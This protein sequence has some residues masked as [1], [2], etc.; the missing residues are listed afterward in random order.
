MPQWFDPLKETPEGRLLKQVR[1]LMESLGIEK[2]DN[3][4]LAAMTEPRD[5]VT[6]GDVIAAAQ[7]N[8]RKGKGTSGDKMHCD[9]MHCKEDDCPSCSS[10]LKKA[11]VSDNCPSC[12]ANPH[13]EC[14]VRGTDAQ[15]INCKM[16]PVAYDS[17]MDDLREENILEHIDEGHGMGRDPD[18]PMPIILRSEVE[19]AMQNG[20]PQYL[21][22]A[23]GEPAR[24]TSY[25][26][27]Q[28]YIAVEDGKRAAPISEVFKMPS[29]SQTGYGPTGSTLHMHINDG[30]NSG[31]L[32]NR[33][34]IEE[35]LADLKKGL[36]YGQE[37]VV[38][39]IVDLLE[40]VYSRL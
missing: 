4:E 40:Q 2:R 15:A 29:V 7:R 34:P 9:K 35:S 19:S 37:G 13:E 28:R 5:K 17:R 6:R 26:T 10:K 11:D 30:G 21:D 32:P 14:R 3:S 24:A 31:N 1:D 18:Q 8:Q 23:G 20:V 12:G 25:T 33:A 16:N 36:T 22:I 39:E 38:A 27:N